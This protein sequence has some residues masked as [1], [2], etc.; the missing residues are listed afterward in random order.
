M[1]NK[2]DELE[3]VLRQTAQARQDAKSATVKLE[4]QRKDYSVEYA[5]LYIDPKIRE[6]QAGLKARQEEA[7]EKVGELL[8]RHPR[9]VP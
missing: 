1:K 4:A 8:E 2:F 5:K 3:K 7:F 6:A 9:G